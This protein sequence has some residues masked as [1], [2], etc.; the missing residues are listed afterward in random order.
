VIISSA[1]MHLAV[2]FFVLLVFC[3]F[4]G[5]TLYLGSL[6][7]PVVLLPLVL[8]SLGCSWF[9]ASLGV[10]LR[11]MAQVIGIIANVSL[12]MAPV[13]YPIDALPEEF[14]SI[15]E[16]NPIT[17]PVIQVRELLLWGAPVQWSHW[18]TSLIVCCFVC[19]TGYLW[20]Q[21][22]RRGFSDVI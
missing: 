8:L 11:D 4:A 20:F 2:N 15:V 5:M 6:L 19:V 12:F 13:F 14:R 22:T 10:Y 17:L 16:W 21:K 9:L 18:V 1:L 3:R 7:V